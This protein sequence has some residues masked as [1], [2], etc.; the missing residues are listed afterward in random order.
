MK[1]NLTLE[2]MVHWGEAC[3]EIEYEYSIHSYYNFKYRSI[4]GRPGKT[5]P[6]N[7]ADTENIVGS[8]S[9]GGMVG[10]E[11][12]EIGWGGGRKD[13]EETARRNERMKRDTLK[14][15]PMLA[16]V[17]DMG[18]VG[19]V[20]LH[21]VATSVFEVAEDGMSA[22]A[23]FY[24]PGIM[25][26]NTGRDGMQD[27]SIM[28]E[29]YGTDWVFENGAWVTLHNHVAEDFTEDMDH[30]NYAAEAWV[31]LMETGICAARLMHVRPEGIGIRGPA[32]MNYSP[33]QVPQ[34]TLLPPEPYETL[35]RSEWYVAR[36][37]D[38]TLY[39]TVFEVEDFDPLKAL[40]RWFG[41]PMG[42]PLVA[43][44]GG[45]SGGSGGFG[46]GGP[47]APLS[48]GGDDPEKH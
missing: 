42:G 39:S 26:G 4:G 13:P 6:M 34:Y 8:H 16:D 24:T 14:Q 9:F 43:E 44:L 15:Y 36:P 11:N 28:W 29:R 37:G 5:S 12:A 31:A 47:G 27:G 40:T 46:P 32:H 22:R 35:S 18:T 2:Q 17:Y 30:I 38:G 19:S 48:G 21:S 7:W 33:V 20:G 45:G 3:N 41:A 10:Y 23:S 25:A 1:R